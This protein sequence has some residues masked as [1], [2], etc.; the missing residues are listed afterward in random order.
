MASSCSLKLWSTL[1]HRAWESRR[2]VSQSRSL[3]SLL[4]AKVFS[5]SLL[6][7]C[8]RILPNID[9]ETWRLA[10]R[11]VGAEL[12]RFSDS[13]GSPMSLS[14]ETLSKQENT[15]STSLSPLFSSNSLQINFF[16]ISLKG[17][18]IFF[19]LP[20]KVINFWLNKRFMIE[21]MRMSFQDSLKSWTRAA[22]AHNWCSSEISWKQT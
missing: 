16:V 18:I 22:G 17:L 6:S 21:K 9:S 8:S 3:A 7:S 10:R 2:N 14:S 20:D 11:F 15:L 13:W 4:A 19:S 5:T 12:F 1:L